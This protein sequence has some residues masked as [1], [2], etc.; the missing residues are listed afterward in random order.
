MT[1][2][3]EPEL[4]C[5][6]CGNKKCVSAVFSENSGGAET[7]AA[8]SNG[9]MRNQEVQKSLCALLDAAEAEIHR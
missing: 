7:Q 2:C 6:L 3:F 9:R 5:S 8:G 1:C 4:C